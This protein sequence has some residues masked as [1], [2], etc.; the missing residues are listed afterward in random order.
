MSVSVSV[1]T[2]LHD[3]PCTACGGMVE[4]ELAAIY[5]ASEVCLE[6]MDEE[7]LR[8]LERD[9]N[10]AAKLDHALLPA[11]PE[12]RGWDVGV[13]YRPSR[14]LSGDFYDVRRHEDGRLTV[15][16]GDVM[17][18]GFP[19]ALLRAGLQSTIKALTPEIVSPARVLEKANRHF[20]DSASPGR[21]ASA[22]LASVDLSTGDLCYAN[23]GHLPA[24]VK[25]RSDGFSCLGATGMVLGAMK[26][27]R[28]EDVSVR[29]EAGDLLVAYSDG[30]TEA[31][32]P[33]GAYFD[34]SGLTRVLEALGGEPAQ[35]VAS[36]V[37]E[38]VG[39]FAPGD[40]SDDRTLL[41]VR[42][43]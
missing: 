19:A 29:I 32:D 12:V 5:P 39:R 28:F 15:L 1:E 27:V 2:E 40:P 11:L 16:V 3:H 9:L 18:K 13:H 23:A 14:I 21:L 7:A 43:S 20:L 42:R 17:G 30:I 26:D 41:A 6:C 38:A 24:L 22:F 37:A 33:M 10:Q 25:S 36:R 35:L 31:S 34:E 4:R 8:H